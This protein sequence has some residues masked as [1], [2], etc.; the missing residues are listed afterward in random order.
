[1]NEQER[2]DF[3]AYM[4]DFIKKVSDNK[5][6]A[7]DFLVR[8]GIYTKDGILTEPYQNLCIPPINA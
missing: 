1:M 5:E 4:E 6:M 7:R 2:A 8:A 3:V